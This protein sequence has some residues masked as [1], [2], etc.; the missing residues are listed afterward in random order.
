MAKSYLKNL[1]AFCDGITALADKGRATD[2]VN[3]DLCKIF[4]AVKHNILL[5]KTERHGFDGGY[6][7][8][9]ELD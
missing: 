6:L 7:V 9:K 8:D 5:S 4:D 1:V 2:V 3:P